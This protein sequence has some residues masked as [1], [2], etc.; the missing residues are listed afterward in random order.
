MKFIGSHTRRSRNISF[1]N[2][3]G[4]SHS[5]VGLMILASDGQ[6][7]Q[8]DGLCIRV[9]EDFVT[10]PDRVLTLPLESELPHN[11]YMEIIFKKTGTR[12]LKLIHG[13]ELKPARHQSLRHK[14]LLT[15]QMLELTLKSHPHSEELLQKVADVLSRCNVS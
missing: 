13:T 11:Q 4:A 3:I 2:V 9:W 7:G 10:S 5:S 6:C 1:N 12:V 15:V 8:A 14:G